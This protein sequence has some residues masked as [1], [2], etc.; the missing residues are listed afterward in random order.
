MVNCL[1]KFERY[2]VVVP[3]P[4]CR[5][6]PYD[7]SATCIVFGV[8]YARAYIPVTKVGDRPYV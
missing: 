8:P 2:F 3:S 6:E 1:G 5:Y 7:L 4:V